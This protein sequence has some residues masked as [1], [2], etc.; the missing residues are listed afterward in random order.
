MANTRTDKPSGSARVL[1][2]G[3]SSVRARFVQPVVVKQGSLFLLCTEDGDLQADSDQGLYFHDMRYLSAE[4][5]RLDGRPP[6]SL[7]AD[8]SEGHRAL[9]ELTNPDLEDDSGEIRVRKEALGIRREKCLGDDYTEVITIQNYV[10]EPAELT[11]QLVYEAD[12][13]DMFVVR[14]M[15]RGKRGRPHAPSW[16]GSQLTFRYDGADGH[17]RTATL[18][19]SH[20]PD[21][22]HGASSPIA[23]A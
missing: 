17:E 2:R 11:L 20:A 13:A 7:L 19:F 18:H 8:A 21:A 3:R 4:T 15:H 14:G 22:R 5:L 6:V 23:C 16:H 1:H 10:P 9:F 12:F